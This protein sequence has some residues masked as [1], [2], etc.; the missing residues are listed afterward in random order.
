MK[1]PETLCLCWLHKYQSITIHNIDISDVRT[2][3]SC[4][5]IGSRRIQTL[6][7]I[8]VNANFKLITRTHDI[9]VLEPVIT[10][11]TV[12]WFMAQYSLVSKNV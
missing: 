1:Q 3:A 5:L 4:L 2:D 11:F 6:L 10:R 8:L 9:L 7:K 12:F